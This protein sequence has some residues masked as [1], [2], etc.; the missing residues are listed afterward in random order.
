MVASFSRLVVVLC[1]CIL[2]ASPSIAQ[3]QNPDKLSPK[4]LEA[5]GSYA[6][7]LAQW[8]FIIIGGSLLLV[9]GTSHRR[10]ASLKIRAVYL[11][12]LPPAWASLAWSIYYGTRAQQ[13]YLA[14][15]LYPRTTLEFATQQL[16]RDIGSQ[17][18]WMLLGMS[19]LVC[20]VIIYLFW[21]T[22]SRDVPKGSGEV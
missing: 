12:F 17:L 6:Q 15:M 8:E 21:W 4:A 14:Y 3:S 11:I 19:F 7:S 10:P 16:N 2:C 5:G 1:V 13:V 22:L 20:W 9:V 18:L